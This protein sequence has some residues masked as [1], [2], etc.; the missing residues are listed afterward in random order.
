MVAMVQVVQVI[1][2]RQAVE[3]YYR[4]DERHEKRFEEMVD[5]RAHR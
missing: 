4:R 5:R 2:V 1:K 3:I